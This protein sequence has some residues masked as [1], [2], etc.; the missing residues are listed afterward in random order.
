MDEPVSNYPSGAQR[1]ELQE[2]NDFVVPTAGA[3]FFVPSVSAILNELTAPVTAPAAA[4]VALVERGSDAAQPKTDAAPPA[5]PAPPAGQE[6]PA[7]HS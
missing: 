4:T 6:S 2:P 7:T 1:S 3:Y 5:A